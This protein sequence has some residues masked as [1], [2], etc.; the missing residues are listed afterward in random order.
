MLASSDSKGI[1]S[2]PDGKVKGKREIDKRNSQNLRYLRGIN[3]GPGGD[4]NISSNN[5]ECETKEIMF[6]GTNGLRLKELAMEPIFQ[7]PKV[8]KE[9]DIGA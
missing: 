3:V 4:G 9:P 1:K 8:L 2:S 6:L 7:S 5:T